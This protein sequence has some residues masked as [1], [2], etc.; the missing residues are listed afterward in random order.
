M[1]ED[2][3]EYTKCVSCQ[4]ALIYSDCNCP[5]CGKREECECEM[6]SLSEYPN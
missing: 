1:R 6:M 3:A 5:F 4:Q 2:F